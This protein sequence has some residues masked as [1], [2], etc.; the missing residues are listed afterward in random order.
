VCEECGKPITESYFNDRI[1]LEP[2][3]SDTTKGAAENLCTLP[4]NLRGKAERPDNQVLLSKM[5]L[6]VNQEPELDENVDMRA[7]RQDVCQQPRQ[8]HSVLLQEVQSIVDCEK[9]VNNQ[10]EIHNIKGICSDI[11]PNA[12]GRVGPRIRDGTS[13]CYGEN[14]GQTAIKERGCASQKWDKIGQSSRKS[15]T[16]NNNRAQPLA[17]TT[18]KANQMPTLRE[19]DKD[20][21][22]CP[23][24]GSTRLNVGITL[25]PFFGA[26]TTGLVAKKLGRHYIGIEL[27]EAYIGMAQ[28]RIAATPMR[29][30]NWM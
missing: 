6:C 27:N 1:V 30:D 12:P 18:T 23:Y 19:V 21:R 20:V 24:C 8:E 9:S 10:G 17:Q 29:L 4:E 11:L 3:G 15:R 2:H 22:A 16:D 14:G 5:L 7:M 26:G 28:K 13:A 25:D